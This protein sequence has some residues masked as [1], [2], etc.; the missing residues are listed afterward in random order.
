MGID[1]SAITYI[2]QEVIPARTSSLDADKPWE[3]TSVRSYR[4]KQGHSFE[5]DKSI[6]RWK[7][8]NVCSESN[9]KN[10]PFRMNARYERQARQEKIHLKARRTI[11]PR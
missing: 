11:Q 6:G 7:Y 8:S 4:G 10:I 3:M 1:M 2:D 5:R 9:G